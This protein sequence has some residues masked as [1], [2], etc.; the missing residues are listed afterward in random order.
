MFGFKQK[1]S[2]LG[3]GDDRTAMS[4]LHLGERLTSSART[5]V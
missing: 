4:G 5:I 2:G 3:F 1:S